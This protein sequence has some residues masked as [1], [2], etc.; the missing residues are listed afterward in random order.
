M[1][2]LWQARQAVDVCRRRVCAP[3]DDRTGHRPRQQEAATSKAD[4]CPHRCCR[5]RVRAC[6]AAGRRP[7]PPR[8]PPS[9]SSTRRCTRRSCGRA[10]RPPH[11][12]SSRTSG[13]S[14]PRQAG[15][16]ARP[17]SPPRR[18]P[19]ASNVLAGAECWRC[20]ALAVAGLNAALDAA[21]EGGQSA[22]SC[23]WREPALRHTLCDLHVRSPLPSVAILP[24]CP[25]VQRHAGPP[26]VTHTDK[27]SACS[28]AVP[29]A[30]DAC[31]SGIGQS[32][33]VWPPDRH[34]PHATAQQDNAAVEVSIASKHSMCTNG[35]IK[36]LGERAH[37][38]RHV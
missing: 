19:G 10:P 17:A 22:G 32:H 24:A 28:L 3:G 27:Q 26:S 14:P 23:C 9:W 34:T 11:L 31:S 21:D 30:K 33:T 7:S 1:E 6:P 12:R 38:L 4:S 16:S 20:L 5:R 35:A 8:A 15:A 29:Q 37:S 36:A 25:P 18:R 2:L 13:R